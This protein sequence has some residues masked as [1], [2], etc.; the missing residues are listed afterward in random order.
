MQDVAKDPL[1]HSGR[2]GLSTAGAV[3]GVR[4]LSR[5]I[6]NHALVGVASMIT[7]LSFG[8]SFGDGG[9]NHP[10][11]LI[12]GMRLAD[13]AFLANDWWAA[14]TSHYHHAFA[15]LTAGLSRLDI[16][17]WGMAVGN[18]AAGLLVLAMLYHLLSLTLRDH[19]ATAWL[20]VTTLFFC[21]DGTRSVALTYLFSPSLQPSTIGAVFFFASMLYFVKGRFPS[22][23][24]WLGVSSMFHSNF[25]LLAFPFFG[26]AHLMLGRE[27]LPRRLLCQLG[28]STLALA[29]QLPS[30]L[31]VMGTELP[32]EVRSEANHIL[33]NIAVPF[34]YKPASYLPSFSGFVGWCVIALSLIRSFPADGPGRGIRIL[35]CSS[36]VLIGSA[37]LLTTVVF[38][39]PVSRLFV[40]RLAPFCLMLA[41][42]VV[43]HVLIASFAAAGKERSSSGPWSMA[44]VWLGFLFVVLAMFHKRLLWTGSGYPATPS[45]AMIL[46]GFGIAGFWWASAGRWPGPRIAR[47]VLSG[48]GV[49]VLLFL[50]L[51]I[52]V[53]DE[54]SPR[55]YNLLHT[56][57]V[58]ES[59]LFEWAGRT[60]PESLFIVPPGMISF[61]LFAGRAVVADAKAV[62][63][64]PDEVLE[65]YERMKGICGEDH[66]SSLEEMERGYHLMDIGR[67]R[68]AVKRYGVDYVVAYKNM[69]ITESGLK[70]VFENEEF[71]VLRAPK[72][73]VTP[74]DPPLHL[75]GGVPGNLKDLDL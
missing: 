8:I 24:A 9:S 68:E 32:Q 12:S 11:Y 37:T 52:A 75:G 65:W 29:V 63:F 41:Y 49:R 56:S 31:H 54:F 25:L 47:A 59:G 73:M 44:G 17:P 36:M 6:Y 10:V 19:A 43:A 74:P 69:D 53:V 4:A 66:V 60:E 22:S 51:C 30:I 2:N 13:P 62:P 7:A 3:T 23:G 40:W 46:T 1:N 33:V 45:A 70:V 55:R 14:H 67:L 26:L 27:G 38:V 18:I 61:R 72:R 20:I 21:I 5:R 58:H 39:D 64:R 42:V 57:H 16:L 28:F 35:F 15:Y 50:G 71:K 48:Q 34:H